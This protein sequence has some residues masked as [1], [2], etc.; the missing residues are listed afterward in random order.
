MMALRR[1]GKE[2]YRFNY[3]GEGH[4]LR[5]WVNMLDY[6]QRMAEFFD[7]HLRGAP[8]PDWMKEG[9]KAWEKAAETGN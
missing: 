4:G 8:Q 3:N 2:A 1:L 9:I 7:H 5:K 6:T